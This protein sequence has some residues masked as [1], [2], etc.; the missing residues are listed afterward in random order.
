MPAL[1]KASQ[2]RFRESKR[3][4]K[5]RE[6]EAISVANYL[7]QCQVT[8]GAGERQGEDMTSTL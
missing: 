7:A 2:P 1:D 5:G 6:A 4:L 3:L 8:P